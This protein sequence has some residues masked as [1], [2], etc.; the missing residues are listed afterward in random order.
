[1]SLVTLIIKGG[2]RKPCLQQSVNYL[3]YTVYW[4]IKNVQLHYM[5][6]RERLKSYKHSVV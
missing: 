5:E 6:L 3:P 1:M 4:A 2:E